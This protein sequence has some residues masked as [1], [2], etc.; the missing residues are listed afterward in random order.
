VPASAP[1]KLQRAVEV[2]N[3]GLEPR[4]VAGVARALGAPRVTVRLA[5]TA[6]MVWIIVAWDLCWYRFEVDLADAAPGARLIAEGLELEELA[7]DDLVPNAVA[8]ENGELAVQ[9]EQ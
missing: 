5:D 7:P 3:A 8:D 9:T 2:F 6:G 4:R 1:I